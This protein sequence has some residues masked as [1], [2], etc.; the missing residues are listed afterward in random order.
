MNNKTLFHRHFW[1]PKYGKSSIRTDKGT[2][3]AT[4]ARILYQPHV[5]I[6]TDVEMIREP[7]AFLRAR[8]DAKLTPF[9]DFLCDKDCSTNHIHLFRGKMFQKLQNLVIPSGVEGCTKPSARFDSAQRD[10]I[11]FVLTPKSF[12]PCPPRPTAS[13]AHRRFFVPHRRPWR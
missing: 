11:L 8:G 12:Q 13:F 3:D 9:A 6:T 10:E 1:F 7:Q 2:I 5:P 4:R